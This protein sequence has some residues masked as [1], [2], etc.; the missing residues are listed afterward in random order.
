MGVRRDVFVCFRKQTEGFFLHDTSG[1]WPPHPAFNA[2]AEHERLGVFP[3]AM[4]SSDF[5][6]SPLGQVRSPAQVLRTE[7]AAGVAACYPVLTCHCLSAHRARVTL[8]ATC[9]PSSTAV[10]PYL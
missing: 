3:R 7:Y 2:T 4:A 1:R 5:C 9:L 6:L 8:T 10:C